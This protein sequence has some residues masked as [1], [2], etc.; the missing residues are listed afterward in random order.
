MSLEEHIWSAEDAGA[1]LHFRDGL[2]F[3]YGLLLACGSVSVF[4][5]QASVMGV[6]HV[7]K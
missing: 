2:S 6:Y 5:Q 3:S 7:P 4:T 1:L